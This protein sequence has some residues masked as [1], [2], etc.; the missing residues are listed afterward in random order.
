M[1]A[2]LTAYWYYSNMKANWL[3]CNKAVCI[4]PVDICYWYT[5]V[6]ECAAPYSFAGRN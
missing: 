2:T 1:V 5:Y 6:F 4:V 3:I